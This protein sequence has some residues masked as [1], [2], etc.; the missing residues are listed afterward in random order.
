MDVMPTVPLQEQIDTLIRENIRLKSQLD[1]QEVDQR[2]LIEFSDKFA[3]YTVGDEFFHSLVRYIAEQTRLDFVFLGELIEPVP[4]QFAIRT[5]ALTAYGQTVGNIQYDLPDG[6]CEQVIQGQLSK[7]PSQCRRLF[8]KNQTLVQFNV[9]GYI[10]YPLYDTKGNAFGILTVMH[11]STIDQP[12]YIASLLKIVAKRAEF[13]LERTKYEAD[14]KA[15]NEELL[16]KNQE[17]TNRNAELASFSYVASH[18]LQEPLRKIRSFGDRLKVAY[19]P[20]LDEE[21]AD[22]IDRMVLAAKRMSLLIKDLLDYSRLTLQSDTWRPQSLSEIVESVANELDMSIQESGAQID[23][24]ELAIVPGDESQLRQLFQNLLSNAL[25]FTQP[26]CVPHIRIRSTHIKRSDL[27]AEFLLL[28]AP[29]DYA[30]IDVTDNGIGFDVQHAER[31]FGTFQ[32]LHGQGKYPG[33]G[34]GLAIAKK[35]TENHRGFIKAMSQPGQG[36]TFLVYLPTQPTA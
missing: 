3:T 16:A 27:P 30:L 8:P 7:Y 24:G 10:G 36:A 9:E 34:I 25:K 18:D 32:R 19:A 6:P 1:Q 15:V 28:A 14:L 21:G 22:I 4:N 29:S 31:I 12:E 13:E 20:H 33:T 11:Q 5:I 23:I 2:F 17:L 26:D 35:I